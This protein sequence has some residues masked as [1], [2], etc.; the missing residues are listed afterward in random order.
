MYEYEKQR[1]V[2]D[3]FEHRFGVNVQVVNLVEKVDKMEFFEHTI[4]NEKIDEK[5]DEMP[6]ADKSNA[7]KSIQ[8]HLGKPQIFNH[9][10]FRETTRVKHSINQEGTTN[11]LPKGLNSGVNLGKPLNAVNDRS[12][13]NLCSHKEQFY[14]SCHCVGT[15]I[16]NQRY[17]FEKLTQGEFLVGAHNTKIKFLKA[18]DNT[19]E[20]LLSAFNGSKKVKKT[21]V[22][23]YI[24]AVKPAL[25]IQTRQ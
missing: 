20:V 14:T 16:V 11:N 18:Y 8:I 6:N 7:D 10:L 15:E 5:H 17:F 13:I 23:L 2:S 1:F 21:S 19:K 9:S 4:K 3:Y 12:G 24:I 22:S 25:K